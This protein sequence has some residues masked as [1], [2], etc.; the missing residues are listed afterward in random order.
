[1]YLFALMNCQP[2]KKT[3]VVEL[4][5]VPNRCQIESCSVLLASK[6]DAYIEAL[7]WLYRSQN[8]HARVLAALTEDKC[9]TLGGWTRDQFYRWT[10]EYL[11]W[12][13]YHEDD[14]NLPKQALLALKPVIEYDAEVMGLF[15]SLSLQILKMGFSLYLARTMRSRLPAIK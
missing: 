5:K 14:V 13:W 15:Y 1:M 2:A 6:G 9:V 4:L 12:L 11:Q 8:Q 7:L 3:A 10:A